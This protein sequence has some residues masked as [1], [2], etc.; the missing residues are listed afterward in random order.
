MKMRIT[1]SQRGSPFLELMIASSSALMSSSHDQHVPPRDES[2]LTN[3]AARRGWPANMR[4]GI[5]LMTKDISNGG[6]GSALRPACNC[7]RNAHQSRFNQSWN[8]LRSRRPYPTKLPLYGILPGFGNGVQSGAVIPSAPAGERQHHFHLLRL[9]FPLTN[10]RI[11]FF[12]PQP[13]AAVA[14]VATPNAAL[15]GEHS[16]A[17]GLT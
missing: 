15:L 8:L 12:P 17:R 2:E 5:E 9:N 10:F 13:D 11:H 7:R 3:Y 1:N 4:A 16:R 14:L 6:R